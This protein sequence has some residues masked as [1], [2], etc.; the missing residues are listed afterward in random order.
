MR[1]CRLASLDQVGLKLPHAARSAC[2]VNE[3]GEANNLSV[4]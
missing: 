4:E 2:V 3:T 1:P